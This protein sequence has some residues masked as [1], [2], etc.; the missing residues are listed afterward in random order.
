[1]IWLAL[2]STLSAF[3]LLGLSTDDH[4]NR[5]FGTRPAPLRKRRMRTA[6]WG[7]LAAALPLAARSH[8]WVFGPVL[9]CGL[10]M[11]SAAS[12]FLYLNFAAAPVKKRASPRNRG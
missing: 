7:M 9:W 11:V 3:A 12:V 6:A 2:L 10:I 4:H 5:R 1:M 8:G